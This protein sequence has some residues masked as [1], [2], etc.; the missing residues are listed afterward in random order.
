MYTMLVVYLLI[1]VGVSFLCSIMEAVYLS[2]TSA[3]VKSHEENSDSFSK[4]LTQYAGTDKGA[5]ISAILTLNTFAHTIG[6]AGV[7][8]E[9]S[10][11]FKDLGYGDLESILLTVTS[12]VLTLIILIFSEIIPKQLGNKHWRSLISVVLKITKPM[13]IILSPILYLLKL[14][15]I[16]QDHD[17]QSE[18]SREEIHSMSEMGVTSGSLSKAEGDML[19]SFL[20]AYSTSLE[21]IM[22]PI[23]SVN[24][25]SETMTLKEFA[26]KDF[27]HTRIPCFGDDVNDIKGYVN[28]SELLE[29]IVDNPEKADDKV[30]T[31]LREV[32]IVNDKTPVKN[33]LKTF[34]SKK[35][36]LAV[37]QN[38]F[39][40]TLGIVTLE[41]IVELYFD[42]EIMDEFDKIED[43]QKEL[44]DK[45][46]VEDKIKRKREE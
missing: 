27:E 7:G 37:I 46:T 35:S 18:I 10:N 13:I 26:D 8:S 36:H 15:G 41:D 30:S 31:L 17:V 25:V 39:V 3:F 1:S 33:V 23:P 11:I 9:A 6:A 40:T 21:D 28:K 14:M 19:K 24:A 20:K 32:L 34:T 44:L 5:T 16:Q 45:L 42:V 43:H 22:V 29:T 4:E 2:I 38:K 12:V